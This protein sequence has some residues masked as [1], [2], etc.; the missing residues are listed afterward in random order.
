MLRTVDAGNSAG[1]QLSILLYSAKVPTQAVFVMHGVGSAVK[2]SGIVR[3]MQKPTRP[4]IH[5][6]TL[7][8]CV[9]CLRSAQEV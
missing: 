6:I 5:T 3:G 1:F 7:L 8:S 2:A 4:D 9:L